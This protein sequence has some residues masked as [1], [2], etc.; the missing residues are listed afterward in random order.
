MQEVKKIRK[1]GYVH[2]SVLETEM[3]KRGVFKCDI[4]K[5]LGIE[6]STLSYKIN[7]KREFTLNEALMIWEKWFSDIPINK[8]FMHSSYID[9]RN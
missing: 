4:S 6:L 5:L 2:F 9:T 1:N 7:G 3:M 8:L